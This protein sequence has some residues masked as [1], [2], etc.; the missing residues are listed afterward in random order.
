MAAKVYIVNE[1][2]KTNHAGEKARAID[3]RPAQAF[4]ELVFL[5]PAGEPPLDPSAWL[6]KMREMLQLFDMK[7]DYLLPVGH[8]AL[9]VAAAAIIGYDNAMP[10]HGMQVGPLH[11]TL[12]VLVWCGKPTGYAPVRLPLFIHPATQS[13]EII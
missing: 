4:G 1:P 7:N 10:E 13:P 3:L 9:L 8:P 2:L 12:S 6:P 11:E 5:S